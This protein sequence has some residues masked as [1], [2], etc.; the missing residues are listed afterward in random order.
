M[1]LKDWPDA[2]IIS[3]LGHCWQ[4]VFLWKK[5]DREADIWYNV[6]E[7]HTEPNSRQGN[8]GTG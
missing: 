6:F 8:G 1:P 3:Y 7:K 2:A 4:V 5:L